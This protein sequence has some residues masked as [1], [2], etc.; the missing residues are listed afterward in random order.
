LRDVVLAV[1]RITWGIVTSVLCFGCATAEARRDSDPKQV[2]SSV[3]PLTIDDP[4]FT[5][6]QKVPGDDALRRLY[7]AGDMKM[8]PCATPQEDGTIV[9]KQCPSA[10][11]VFGPYV[12]VPAKSDVKL[13]FDI[14]S[15]ATLRVMSD[16]LSN[17]AKQFHGA[18]DEQTILSREKRTISYRIHVFDAVRTVESRI[19]IRTDAP[20]DFTISNLTLSVE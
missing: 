20:V 15:S 6:D 8:H 17:S 14:E 2:S 5:E 13:R 9:G 19:G 10:L 4:G 12:T 11:V 7:N 3:S 1:T 16:V 18:I